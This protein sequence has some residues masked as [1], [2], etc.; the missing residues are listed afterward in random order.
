MW[1]CPCTMI[2]NVVVEIVSCSVGEM[3]E[4]KFSTSSK[5][6]QQQQKCCMQR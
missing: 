6:Q 3:G 5:Q 2:G 1:R 4:M